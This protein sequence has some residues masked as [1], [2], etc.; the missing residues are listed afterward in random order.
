MF[1]SL[2]YHRGW[3]H[4]DGLHNGHYYY[5]LTDSDFGEV[6]IMID[7]T[8]ISDITSIGDTFTDVGAVI[9]EYS[10]RGLNV[11]ANLALFFQWFEK[12][13]FVE[14]TTQIK[15]AEDYQPLFTPEIK[16]ALEKYL[17]LL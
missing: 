14:I 13:N 8:M 5:D 15:W 10:K 9:Q 16:M 1:Q 7:A 3:N 4:C 17:S 11:A 6:R 12:I 2:K